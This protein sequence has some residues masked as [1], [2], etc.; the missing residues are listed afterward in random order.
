MIP[1]QSS[2]QAF[3]PLCLQ[4]NQRGMQNGQMPGESW[5]DY[6]MRIRQEKA[7]ESIWARS[8]SPPTRR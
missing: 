2:T 8:P 1:C 3:P 4:R 5:E 6:R 7:D